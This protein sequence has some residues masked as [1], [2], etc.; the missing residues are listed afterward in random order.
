MKLK[1]SHNAR[2]H[3]SRTTHFCT[4]ASSPCGYSVRS[5]LH[6][7]LLAHRILGFINFW[8]IGGPSI[9]VCPEPHNFRD[10]PT[11]A[12]LN[13]FLLN[14]SCLHIDIFQDLLPVACSDLTEFLFGESNITAKLVR[15]LPFRNSYSKLG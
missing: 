6:V 3:K 12:G 15:K 10:I 14:M 7:A 8:K 1:L 13:S 5:F 4:V 11:G 9:H 2:M